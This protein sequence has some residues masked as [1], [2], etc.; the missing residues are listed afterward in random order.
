MLQKRKALP[1]SQ[2]KG[3]CMT[4]E[5]VHILGMPVHLT[6]TTQAVQRLAEQSHLGNRQ[7]VIAQNPEKVMKALQDSEL[8]EIIEQ[9]ATLLIADGVGLTIAGKILG[10]P[11][12]E[13]VTGIGLFA[14]LLKQANQ[15]DKRIFLYGASL[16]VLT[17]AIAVIQENYPKIVIA[18]VV[19]GYEQDNEAIIDRIQTAKPDYL[20]VALGSPRQ[21]KWIAKQ[22]DQLPVQIVMGVGGSFDVLAGKVQRAPEW[23]QQSGLEWLHRLLK[24][25]SRAFRMLNL[26]KFLWKVLKSRII[27]K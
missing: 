11:R 6:N 7:F 20:F 10:L 25:P 8:A 5:K 9:K 12:I 22:L 14:E 3:D 16:E 27:T 24:Q 15:T 4:I 1:I 23:M 13:R 19:D 2:Y 26:P 17:K 18:G 21:E